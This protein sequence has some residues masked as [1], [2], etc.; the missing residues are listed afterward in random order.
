MG[1]RE[2]LGQ[3]YPRGHRR[4][5]AVPLLSQKVPKGQLWQVTLEVAFV[6]ALYIPRGQ[7]VGALK[8]RLGSQ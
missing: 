2:V 4:A 8:R 7:G 1:E 6:A 5:A 3:K